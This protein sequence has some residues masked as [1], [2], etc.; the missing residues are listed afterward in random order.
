MSSKKEYLEKAIGDVD[1]KE[2]RDII[3]IAHKY[4]V[5]GAIERL[6]TH[7]VKKQDRIKDLEKRVLLL[8]GKI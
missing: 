7:I 2:V 4:L 6:A 1:D 3:K 5:D 8:G